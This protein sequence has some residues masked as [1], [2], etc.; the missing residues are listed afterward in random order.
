MR[1]VNSVLVSAVKKDSINRK[2]KSAREVARMPPNRH[3]YHNA[4]EGDGCGPERNSVGCR[5][6]K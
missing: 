3:S 2:V 6:E 5:S 1:S 4:N